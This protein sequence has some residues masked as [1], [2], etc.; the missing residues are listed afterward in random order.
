[1]IALFQV[2]VFLS[3]IAAPEPVIFVSISPQAYIVERIAGGRAQVR[4]L[5]PPGISSHAY[6]P[7]PTQLRELSRAAMYVR[8]G[9]PYERAAWERIRAANPGMR[10]VEGQKGISVR[11]GEHSH[12]DSHESGLGTDPHVWLDVKNMELLAG[13]VCTALQEL[14]P[15][16]KT[17]YVENLA[18]LLSDLRRLDTELRAMLEPFRGRTFW[19]YHP[20]WGY[21]ADAYGLHQRAIEEQG[22]EPGAH[23]LASLVAR[24]R[25]EGVRVIFADPQFSAK[26]ARVVAEEIGA[27]V[28]MLDPLARDY[29]ATLRKAAKAIAEAIE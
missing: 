20:A 4:V 13:H 16:N 12:G 14:D 3:G 9:V 11:T 29:P 19:V 23:T 18:G 28:E 24:A 27:R 15:A 5:L 6:D 21:F 1:M 10:I 17:H 2:L 8:I 25:A 22:K 26:S 7:T